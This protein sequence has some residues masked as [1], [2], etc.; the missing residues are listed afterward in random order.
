MVTRGCVPIFPTGI[1]GFLIKPE[2]TKFSLSDGNYAYI[3]KRDEVVLCTH[4][5][6]IET[7]LKLQFEL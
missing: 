2:G 5:E 6:G 3:V 7:Q 4:K 1:L